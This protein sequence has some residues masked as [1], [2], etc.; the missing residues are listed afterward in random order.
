MVGKLSRGWGLGVRGRYYP[1]C[2]LGIAPVGSKYLSFFGNFS[3]SF[4]FSLPPFPDSE[5][6]AFLHPLTK[7]VLCYLLFP[8]GLPLLGIHVGAICHLS[9]VTVKLSYN[10][11]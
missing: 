9:K 2:R 5:G 7:V 4:S 3:P 10:E 11:S 1:T 6:F 8:C